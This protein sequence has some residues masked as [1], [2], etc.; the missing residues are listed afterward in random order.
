MNLER[1]K[2]PYNY[3]NSK[4][5]YIYVCLA[6]VPYGFLWYPLILWLA[7]LVCMHAFSAWIQVS[8]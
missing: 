5:S 6:A 4:G 3:I 7:K 8:N 1:H 2:E